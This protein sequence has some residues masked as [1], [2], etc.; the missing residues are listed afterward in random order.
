[1]RSP[2]SV[3]WGRCPLHLWERFANLHEKS[4]SGNQ[5]QNTPSTDW[6][7]LSII[8][9]KR[10]PRLFSGPKH[11]P[12]M[13]KR[14]FL[15]PHFQGDWIPR[16]QASKTGTFLSLFLWIPGNHLLLFNNVSLKN[17]WKG[18]S[19]MAVQRTL[20]RCSY[21]FCANIGVSNLMGP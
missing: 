1:M 8:P 5:K 13:R 11:V 14:E 17:F 21:L 3:V 19:D 2:T 20:V 7:F 16:E 10:Q 18:F 6:H 15:C 4:K 12:H 9:E